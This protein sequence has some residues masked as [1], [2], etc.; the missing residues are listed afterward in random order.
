MKYII[1]NDLH[2]HSKLSLCSGDIRQTTKRILKYAKTNGLKTVCLTDHFWDESVPCKSH[3]YAQ[4]NYEHIKKALPLPKD[5]NVRFLFGCETELEMDL[6]LGLSKE[7]FDLFDF[8]IIPLTHFHMD[9]YTISEEQ[10]KSPETRAKAWTDRFD[11]VLNMELP[12][13]K[14]GLAHLTCTLMYPDREGYLELIR[15]IPEDDMRR[16]FSK[17]ASLGVGIELNADDLDFTDE[18]AKTVLRPFF[19]AKECGCKFY[20][21]SD[22]HHPSELDRSIARFERAVEILQ[23]EESDKFIV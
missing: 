21:G 7:K 9:G 12:F 16:L 10:A 11:A 17:A 3:W 15:L 18:E 5:E 1:D 4:Q 13:G 8:I 6:T 20:L 23:L 19:T 14:V 2:I 22:A